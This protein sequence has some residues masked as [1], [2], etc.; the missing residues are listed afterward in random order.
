MESESRNPPVREIRVIILFFTLYL[1]DQVTVLTSLR[2]YYN[3]LNEE[4]SVVSSVD[5][6]NV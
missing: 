4:D 3:T 2:K 5:P 6:R 1:K